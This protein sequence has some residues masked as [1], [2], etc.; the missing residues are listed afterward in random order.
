MVILGGIGRIGKVTAFLAP[1]MAA[2]YVSGALL[3]LMLNL[4][5][6]PG[7]FGT[8][9]RRGV[10]SAGRGGRCRGRGSSS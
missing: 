2:I 8:I 4:G 9:V 1:F 5:S 10:Q 3:I 6:V 7:A